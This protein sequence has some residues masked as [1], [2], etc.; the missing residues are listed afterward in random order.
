MTSGASPEV[1]A[2]LMAYGE[3]L[4]LAFQVVDDV[5]DLIAG[6]HDT[7]KGRG[8]DLQEGVFT[9]PV[10]LACARDPELGSRLVAGDRTL[11]AI[12]PTLR[13]TG[14]LEDAA[15]MATDLGAGALDE[16][17]AVGSAAWREGMET[18]VD[19]VL[20]QLR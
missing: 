17:T 7:G 20:R 4:G 3:K 2:A 10:L 5:L 1:R 16:I 14:A 8:T 12:L 6:T 15:A 19:G 11:D 9:L 18:I 13:A